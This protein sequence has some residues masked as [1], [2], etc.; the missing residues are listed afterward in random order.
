[1]TNIYNQAVEVELNEL[2]DKLINY[3]NVLISSSQIM[4]ELWKYHPGNESFI[5]PIKA[6]DDIKSQID[7]IEREISNVEL[8]ILHLKSTI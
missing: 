3:Q 8:Q 1:M 5:N 6:Y 4:E 7:K 2:E